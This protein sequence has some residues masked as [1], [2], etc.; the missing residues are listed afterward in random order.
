[1]SSEKQIL[2]TGATG[3]QGGAVLNELQ[4]K[5]FRF[6]ALTR[7]P[8]G[9]AAKALVAKGV[10]VVAG[11]L[12]DAAS[13]ERALSGVWGVFAV[14]NTWEAG[15]E[16][17]EVQGKRIAELARKAGVQQF[18]YTSVGSAHRATGIPHFDNKWRR[19]ETVRSLGFPSHVVIR[20]VF[21]MENLLSPWFLNGDK[22]VTALDPS[23]RLQMI[24]V[25]DIGRFGA[26]CFTDAAAFSGKAI[27]LA[28][29]A[30]TMPEAA[31]V[32][33]KALGKPLEYLRIPIA[34]GAEEQRGLC[35]DARV[36]RPRR[37]RGGRPR[38]R[39]A[40]RLPAARPRRL[41]GQAEGLTG[42]RAGA[43]RA[44]PPW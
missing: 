23:T 17:E 43:G 16:G 27:D 28:G 34:D 2:I 20:P 37:L 12:D 40:V 29:D 4:G 14:Q 19:E 42:A 15:V 24:A 25:E 44:D 6:R 30:L 9:D 5:G 8:D 1:M 32:L 39:E 11:D 31:A 18:V 10:E 13:L 7:K 26:R 35:A 22:L 33:S 38:A 36:V 21:F 41:G 3:K